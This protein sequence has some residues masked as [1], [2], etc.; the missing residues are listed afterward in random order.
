MKQ[1]ISACG[2]AALMAALL[3]ACGGGA[4]APPRAAAGVD[5]ALVFQPLLEQQ[6][7]GPAEA[8]NVVVRDAGA[9]AALWA[10]I[11]GRRAE[12]APLPPVDF[13]TQMVVGV[14]SGTQPSGCNELHIA[15]AFV[16]SGAAHVEYRQNQLQTFAAC[17]PSNPLSLAL[18][19]RLEGAVVFAEIKP[20]HR[21]Y[22]RIDIAL[23]WD[24]ALAPYSAVLK[25]E[26]A[27]RAVWARH[28]LPGT[29][30]PR[31]DFGKSML[32]FAFGGQ[33]PIGCHS[34]RV[35]DYYSS[36]G[37]L[38]VEL[39]HSTPGPTVLCTQSFIA[40]GDLIEVERGDDPVLFAER[41]LPL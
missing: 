7:G 2:L 23:N 4:T 15:R 25:D 24:V 17:A 37:K 33:F 10:Q 20:A 8:Q 3:G 36:A 19:P 9:W 32:I 30:P 12:P 38:Y 34:T 5:A 21:T 22:N 1:L 16:A 28:A 40:T 31:V 41:T 18:L 35:T 14:F 29:P 6:D 26:A 39:L 11:N 27:L 13:A